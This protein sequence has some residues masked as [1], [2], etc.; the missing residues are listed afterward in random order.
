MDKLLSLLE[1]DARL[2]PTRLGQM[3]GLSPEEV[4]RRIEAYEKG[5]VILGY[6]AIVNDD[7]LVLD[8]V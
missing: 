1:R 2:T 7:K 8:R 6:K 5:G 3:L 4:A